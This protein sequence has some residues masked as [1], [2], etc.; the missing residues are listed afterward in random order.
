ML[1]Y[2]YYTI[3]CLQW[4]TGNVIRYFVL[5]TVYHRDCVARNVYEYIAE[6]FYHY[7]IVIIYTATESPRFNLDLF[8]EAW[9]S[10]RHSLR[11]K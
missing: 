2:S 6:K 5:Q 11:D 7:H 3:I 1:C 10:Y 4:N 9:N 8:V